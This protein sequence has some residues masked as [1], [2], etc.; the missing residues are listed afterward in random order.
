M[1]LSEFA[2]FH[3]PALERDEVKFNLILGLLGRLLETDSPEVRLWTLGT[4]GQCALQTTP[5]NP[6]ILGDLVAEQCYSF[7]EQTLNLDYPGVVGVDLTARLFAERASARGVKFAVPMPQVIQVL[8]DKPIYPVA[9][10]SAR[11]VG[12]A[13]ADLFTEWMIAFFKEA[14]P[15]DR[16]PTRENIER[17]AAA[18]NYQ[19]WMVDG[20]L[21]SMA[22]IVR[23]TRLWPPL[24]GCTPRPPCVAA[25]TAG[26]LLR[27][28]PMR[29][30]RRAGRLCASIP[31][32][33]IRP[34]TAAMPRSASVR[35]TV[36]GTI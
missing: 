2:E 36:P 4:P 10:G 14:T 21:V 29:F 13:D 20:E 23:R 31:T 18:G 25:V 28:W 17:T 24:P 7:A 8:R 15:H 19:F 27:R 30:S 22:G 26:R 3:R 9:R 11:T 1:Q 35:C 6:I 33:A 5:R 32:C 34:R 12:G 16:V